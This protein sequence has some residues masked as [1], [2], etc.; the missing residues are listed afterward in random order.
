MLRKALNAK[1]AKEDFFPGLW[2][3]LLSPYF[4]TR[5]HLLRTIKA[6][7]SPIT[8]KVLDFGCGSKPY[9]ALFT[10]A[11]SYVGVDIEVSGHDHLTSKVDYFY[12]G[13]RLPFDDESFDSIVSFEVFEHVQNLEAMVAELHRV[14]KPGATFLVTTPFLF[15]EHE[16]PYDFRRLSRYGLE[17]ILTNNGFEIVEIVPTTG[18]ILALAQ[19]FNH[20]L[21]REVAPPFA[22]ARAIAQFAVIVP[23]TALAYLCHFLLPKGSSM[24]VNLVAIARKP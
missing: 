12:N 11:D 4:I 24:Y 14:A 15:P 13:V 18:S 6:R 7:T 17:S 5:Y 9:E 23:M 21:F 10:G 2:S 1:L 16:I 8:G 3:F 20:F 22:I 19:G